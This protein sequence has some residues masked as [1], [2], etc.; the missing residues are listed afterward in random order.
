MPIHLFNEVS[1][2]K[3]MVLALAA[4]VEENMRYAVKAVADRDAK[5]AL[6]VIERDHEIDK[7]E[8]EV[9]EECLKILALHQPVANDLRFIIAILKINHDLERIGDLAVS[10]AERA[11]DLTNHARP[12]ID[13]NL[14]AMARK[15]QDMVARSIDAMINRDVQTAREIWLSDDDMDSQN[16]EVFRRVAEEIRKHPDQA[17]ALLCLMSVSRN[18]E[19]IADHASS[20]SKDVLY[21]IE[22]EIVRHRSREYRAKLEG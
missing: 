10:I 13:V 7:T 19:R 9:E 15:A 21:M 4:L 2:L 16:R 3:K 8:V 14:T 6:D 20:I 12:D 18:L 5:L 1:K 17:E 11:H 22:G